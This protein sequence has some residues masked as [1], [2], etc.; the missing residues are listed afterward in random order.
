MPYLYGTFVYDF[1]TFPEV[2]NSLEFN[3]FFNIVNEF[4]VSEKSFYKAKDGYSHYQFLD[5]IEELEYEKNPDFGYRLNSD[6]F[7][8]EHFKTLNK[9]NY[10][11]LALGCSYT[12][13]YGLPEELSWPFLLEKNLKNNIPNIKMFNLGS[14]GLSIDVIIKNLLVF[15]SKYGVPN[16]IFAL[17][18]DMN[19][20]IIYHPDQKRYVLHFPN[21]N[22][23]TNK[24]LD[25]HLF[26]KTKHY[27]FEDIMFY[28]INQIK[29]LETICNAFGIKLLWNSWKGDDSKIYEEM[30]FSNYI[31]DSQD[32]YSFYNFEDS[33][34][35]V[36]SK[37]LKYYDKGRDKNHPGFA[38][39]AGTADLF[40][41][42]WK[43][44]EKLF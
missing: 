18:P 12:F 27:V 3:N 39:S 24:K 20:H 6:L 42:K 8:G 30:G 1:K 10:N 33:K 9:D 23:L 28:M 11:V 31:N 14:P 35:K 17:L 37:F 38:F 7:R 25:K 34:E 26:N 13:G 44:Y 40:F 4:H 21:L 32:W 5:Q 22:N 36:N 2:K 29:M 41:D 19:R 15:I 16:A 43:N